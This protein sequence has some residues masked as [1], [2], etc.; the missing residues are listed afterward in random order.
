MFHDE[1]IF[2]HFF[3]NSEIEIRIFF[4]FLPTM[5]GVLKDCYS[6]DFFRKIVTKTIVLT[7][8]FKAFGEIL[9]VFVESNS[10]TFFQ[11]LISC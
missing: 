2:Q 1:F 3:L 9:E 7:K 4:L 6:L 10:S 8:T 11:V 5:T